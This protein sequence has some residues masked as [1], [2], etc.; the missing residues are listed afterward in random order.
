[1]LTDFQAT[2]S[3]VFV[4]MARQTPS[5]Q[6]H[7]VEPPEPPDFFDD[8]GDS[9]DDDD[10]PDREPPTVKHFT[11]MPAGMTIEQYRE[12]AIRGG[13]RLPK[14]IVRRTN[15]AVRRIKHAIGMVGDFNGLD[16]IP[17]LVHEWD[18]DRHGDS[19]VVAKRIPTA[20]EAFRVEIDICDES[21]GKIEFDARSGNTYELFAAA[22][23]EKAALLLAKAD[24]VESLRR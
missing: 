13:V 19:H 20:A 10:E 14:K 21:L 1:M 2:L 9:G 5:L 15:E 4:P 17:Y 22:L 6:P 23:R 3:P 7:V 11:M 24:L 8:G 16:E 12:E 18:E